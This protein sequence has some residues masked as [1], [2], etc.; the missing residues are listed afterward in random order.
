MKLVDW[1]QKWS[2]GPGF[3]DVYP[4]KDALLGW[5]RRIV[6]YNMVENLFSGLDLATTVRLRLFHSPSQC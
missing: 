1:R 5:K 2:K 4:V 3:V 6:R